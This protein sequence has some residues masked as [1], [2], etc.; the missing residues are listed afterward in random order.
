MR[1]YISGPYTQG[2]TLLNIRDAIL[3]AEEVRAAGHAPFVPHLTA[4]WHML[5]PRPYEDWMQMDLEWVLGSEA[6]IRLPGESLGADREVAQAQLK[7]I[8]VY[9][10]VAHFL[11]RT[12][13][14]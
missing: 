9:N 11:A 14:R 10:G 3:A 2:D 4:F 13:G 7:G 12:V 5:T 8:P 1:V 6:V